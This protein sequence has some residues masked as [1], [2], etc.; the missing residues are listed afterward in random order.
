MKMVEETHKILDPRILVSPTA[1]RVGVF[2]GHSESVNIETEKAFE[3][4]DVRRL[5]EKAPGV[6]LMDNPA[7]LVYPTA[8][9]AD[10]QDA[11]Y[12]GRLRRDP[13]VE[14]GLNMWVVSDNL[15][16]GAALNAVQIAET[17]LA[18]GF[19]ENRKRGK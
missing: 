10:G 11:V 4:E 7:E 1:V 18:R 13:T 19:A 17:L 15:R 14:H 16:K 3:I 9:D 2:R 5:L 8:L 6:R 12:V